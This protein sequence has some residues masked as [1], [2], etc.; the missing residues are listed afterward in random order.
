MEGEGGVC[1]R[2]SVRCAFAEQI[3]AC[4]RNRDREIEFSS[5]FLSVACGGGGSFWKFGEE[6]GF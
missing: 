5:Y 2:G 1:V 6:S 4:I 3:D